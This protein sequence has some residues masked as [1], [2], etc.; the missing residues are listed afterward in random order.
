MAQGPLDTAR[1]P[2]AATTARHPAARQ[3]V[4]LLDSRTPSRDAQAILPAVAASPTDPR[5]EGI[6]ARAVRANDVAAARRVLVTRPDPVFDTNRR[7]RTALHLAAD[8]GQPT[9][10]ILLVAARANANARD[11]DGYTPVDTAKYYAT[12]A[13]Q[14]SPTCLAALAVLLRCGGRPSD[15]ADVADPAAPADVHRRLADEARRSS[16]TVPSERPLPSPTR[17]VSTFPALSLSAAPTPSPSRSSPRPRRPTARP[18][19]SSSPP[20]TPRQPRVPHQAL[21]PTRN[22]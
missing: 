18:P 15:I 2:S 5:R 3:Y 19:L 17:N 13:S 6:L 4:A 9:L 16:R 14:R 10:T 11:R 7:G 12:R 1:N 22:P 21:R 8:A 20:G